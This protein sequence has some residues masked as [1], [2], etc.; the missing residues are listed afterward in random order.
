MKTKEILPVSGAGNNC[1]Y[2]SVAAHF[3]VSYVNNMHDK[4]VERIWHKALEDYLGAEFV[5]KYPLDSIIKG[6]TYDES[7][8][9]LGI[10]F[11]LSIGA[12]SRDTVSLANSF[13]R[14]SSSGVLTQ[15][16]EET[17]DESGSQMALFGITETSLNGISM[18]D[19]SIVLFDDRDTVMEAYSD[20]PLMIN[21]AS[22]GHFDIEV[23]PEHMQALKGVHWD[24]LRAAVEHNA[25][26]AAFRSN[27]KSFFSKVGADAK[28][29]KVIASKEGQQLFQRLLDGKLAPKAGA[30]PDAH[31]VPA[32]GGSPAPQPGAE[33][34]AHQVSAEGGGA[35]AQT[36][37]ET[38]P[39]GELVQ[40]TDV[41][42]G[43]ALR[44]EIVYDAM[45]M[46]LH[47]K[48]YTVVRGEDDEKAQVAYN[49]LSI[50]GLLD[51]V[52][53]FSRG[54]ERVVEIVSSFSK[55]NMEKEPTGIVKSIIDELQ[56]QTD[57][58]LLEAQNTNQE[59]LVNLVRSK[60]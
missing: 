44:K 5:S 25:N 33:P 14:I 39:E 6:L 29:A 38:F 15:C 46:Y 41:L 1:L 21:R 11:R 7:S 9:L 8:Q 52:G 10:A 32:E 49:T 34:D 42:S 60:L 26:I 2:I 57:D 24:G 40:K 12:A 28:A 45:C 35:A 31:Q 54:D 13:E 56:F 37:D 22:Q 50:G 20:I 19:D 53:L 43:D 23:L 48:N 59:G 36:V 16:I 47:S 4:G 30:E 17:R 55:S 51:A 58:E 18:D 27:Q 3:I